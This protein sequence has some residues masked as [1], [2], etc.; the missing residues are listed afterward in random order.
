MDVLNG[1]GLPTLLR[2]REQIPHA[3]EHLGR[4]ARPRHISRLRDTLDAGIRTGVDNECYSSWNE[5]LFVRQ[6][7][8][9]ETALYG[10]PLT[11]TERLSP[12][13]PTAGSGPT[14]QTDRSAACCPPSCRQCIQTYCS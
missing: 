9:I 1:G 2:C 14:W 13:F 12:L 11:M 7:G 6:L 5:K 10:R 3:R 4:L 8:I